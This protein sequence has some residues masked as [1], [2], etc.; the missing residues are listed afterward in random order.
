MKPITLLANFEI[1]MKRTEENHVVDDEP[2]EAE[3]SYKLLDYFSFTSIY[4]SDCTIDRV[5]LQR[6]QWSRWFEMT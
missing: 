2:W 6:I 5:V 3:T 1:Q 4:F